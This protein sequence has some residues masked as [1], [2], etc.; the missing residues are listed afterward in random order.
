LF[1]IN[2]QPLAGPQ[3]KLLELYAGLSEQD[4]GA[5]MAFAEFLARRADAEAPADAPDPVV[6]NP[7][8]IVRP[9]SETVIAAIR[10]LSESY[11]MLERKDL[12]N[13]TSSVM[14]QHVMNGLPSAAAV[15]RL[16][17]LF[18]EHYARYCEQRE[19]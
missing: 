18:R 2:Q 17:E 10:R 1:P 8:E 11:Y 19:S 12:L 9:E 15:D 7:K 13:E 4:R 6:E 16:E 3:K 14:A 5:L